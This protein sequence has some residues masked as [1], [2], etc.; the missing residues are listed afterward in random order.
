MAEFQYRVITPEGKEKKGT[1]EGKSIEQVTGVLKAQKNVILSVSE[2]SLMSRDINFSLGGRVS[3]RDYSIFCRQFVS[4]ISAG[5]SI[6][7]ALEMMRDQTENRTLKKALGEVYEDVS[8]GES[9]AGAMKKHSKVFPSMLCNMV[10]AGEASGS[11]EVAFE[12]MAVQFEKENKLKQSVKKAMIY[13]IVLLVVMVGVLFLMM[14]WVIPNF[15]G[16]FAELDTEL[17]PITQAVVNMSDFVIAKWWLILLVVAAAIALFKAY[18]ASPSGKF[19]LGGIALK[20][21]VFGKLQTKSECARL[22]RTLCTLLG[23]GVPMMDAIEITGRSMENVH[24]KKAMMDAKD[25]VMRGMALSR[26]LKTCGLFPPMV[27]HMVSIGEETGN[28]ET[29]LENVANYYEDDVQVATEQVMAL[30]EPMII[31]VMAI[32]VGVLIMAIMQPM[33]TLYESI[34]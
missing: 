10:E 9:M 25:Q 31:V 3:A 7:N 32:V 21:P 1:M 12:R 20:I 16:M 15:M 22:G 23:A 30:M 19:V 29:M 14:I 34:G 4:I 33:L 18:A 13:P 5:V 6:I 28:I 11:M 2:A 17:P 27:V 24:Y 8:K 26:P